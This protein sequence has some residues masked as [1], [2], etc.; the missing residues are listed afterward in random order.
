MPPAPK[1]GAVGRHKVAYDWLSLPA[2]GRKGRAPSMPDVASWDAV[3]RRHWAALWR[4]PQAVAWEAQGAHE[5]VARLVALRSEFRSTPTP[6]LS[7]EMRQLE[8]RL[9]LNPKAMLQ[10]R[11][12]IAA[13]E[14]ADRRAPAQPA[15]SSARDRLRAIGS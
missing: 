12:R 7:A 4:M 14:V 9:G 1:P 3:A 11:W 13:D 5:F 8:D 10:L 15:G 2:E 6:A